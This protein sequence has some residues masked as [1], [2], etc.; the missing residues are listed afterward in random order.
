MALYTLN[1]TVDGR[2]SRSGSESFATK[3]A[4]NGDGADVIGNSINMPSIDGDSNPN[5]LFM[6]RGIFIFDTS[7]ILDTET[8][9]TAVLRLYIVSKN[10][11]HNLGVNLT[12]VTT[13]SDITIGNSDYNVANHGSV[14]FVAADVDLTGIS[15]SAYLELTLNAS[16]IAHINKTGLTKFSL[17]WGADIDNSAP[18]YN[19]GISSLEVQMSE[20]ATNKPQLVIT[21]PSSGNLVS[22]EI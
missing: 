11:N 21:T 1:P 19:D 8:I 6:A 14:R 12:S 5:Y 18:V 10:D 15:T 13:A 20:N 16:G 7:S 2:A 3:R 22:M 4:G 17:R 9:E